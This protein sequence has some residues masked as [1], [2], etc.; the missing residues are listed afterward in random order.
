M[1]TSIDSDNDL[2]PETISRIRSQTR[3]F[4]STWK[5]FIKNHLGI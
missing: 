2:T 5:T 4:S 1:D 3:Q